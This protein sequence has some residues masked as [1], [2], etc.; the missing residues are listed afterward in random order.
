[1]EL[2]G[3]GPTARG[4]GLLGCLDAD[5]MRLTLMT[6]DPEY[7]N[8]IV[9]AHDSGVDVNGIDA[10]EAKFPHVCLGWP[11]DLLGES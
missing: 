4:W 8:L 1:M 7:M 2:I 9:E 11:E 5:G 3:V 6:D 10:M